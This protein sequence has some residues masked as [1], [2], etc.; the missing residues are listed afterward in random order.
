L[1]S[2]GELLEG[3]L[4]KAGVKVDRKVLDGAPHEFFGTVAVVGDAKDAR[5]GAGKRR[6]EASKG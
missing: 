6:R 3:A 5:S 1:R 2:D 4:K